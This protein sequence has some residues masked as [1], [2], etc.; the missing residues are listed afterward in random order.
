MTLRPGGFRYHLAGW[1]RVPRSF[2]LE[3]LCR[4]TRRCCRAGSQRAVF[5][6][7][8]DIA[9]RGVAPPVK[10]VLAVVHRWPPEGAAHVPHC[11]NSLPHPISLAATF[12][13]GGVSRVGEGHRLPAVGSLS[14]GS[15]P[16]RGVSALACFVRARGP[17]R[18]WPLRR[19]PDVQSLVVGGHRLLPKVSALLHVTP[20][21]RPLGRS[22]QLPSN[23]RTRGPVRLRQLARSA[24]NCS[25]PMAIRGASRKARI[26]PGSAPFRPHPEGH[27]RSEACLTQLASTLPQAPPWTPKSPCRVSF[28]RVS[29]PA[30]FD[31]PFCRSSNRWFRR[32]ALGVSLPRGAESHLE[33]R[34]ATEILLAVVPLLHCQLVRPR[35]R[36]S[37]DE[38]FGATTPWMTCSAASPPARGLAVWWWERH[39]WFERHCSPFLCFPVRWEGRRAGAVCPKAHDF[40]SGVSCLRRARFA[41]RWLFTQKVSS[42]LP[43]W[44]ARCRCRLFSLPRRACARSGSGPR[45]PRWVCWVWRALSLPL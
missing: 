39:R 4:Y 13:P 7:A 42:P 34:A 31:I 6:L 45:R 19:L 28:G 22:H 29:F 40:L 3:I 15:R 36:R 30:D 27:G 1:D 24:A 14:R 33:L 37:V 5:A 35:A 2:S 10:T 25:L 26:E 41:V 9:H 12:A 16:V 38:G 23:N 11:E 43:A 20:V 21:L 18:A 17:E 32:I 8:V 44:F